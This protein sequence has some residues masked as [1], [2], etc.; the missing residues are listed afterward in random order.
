MITLL[1]L[2]L[3]AGSP[4]FEGSRSAGDYYAAR[5]GTSWS[6]LSGKDKV[7]VR[8]SAVE[9]WQ[10]R[11]QVSWGKRSTGGNW[12]VKEGA[13]LERLSGVGEVVLLPAA[14]HLGSQWTGPSSIERNGKDVSQFEVIA[15]DATVEV[16]AGTF[17]KCLAVLETSQ[18]GGVLTHYWAPNVGKVAVKSNDD[19]LLK[20]VAFV[21]GKRG[22][23]GGD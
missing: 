21:P 19:F 4:M 18:S 22:G 2:V 9:N 20:L 16:P 13:W 5:S 12:R 14:M 10:A 11:V 7:S 15:T 17:E 3:L 6:Y 1:A 23:G 8:V